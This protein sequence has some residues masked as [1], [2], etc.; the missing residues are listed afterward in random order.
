MAKRHL[1]SLI[2]GNGKITLDEVFH[3]IK[4]MCS[5]SRRRKL[6]SVA[7]I[8]ST[9]N[10]NINE[11]TSTSTT[12]T[13]FTTSTTTSSTTSTP[14][15]SPSSPKSFHHTSGEV[16]LSSEEVEKMFNLVDKDSNG[17]W[18]LDEFIEGVSA[19]PA[20]ARMLNTTPENDRQLQRRPAAVPRQQHCWNSTELNA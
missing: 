2:L 19:H 1:L 4:C 17:Y 13:T 14:P 16:S 10:N 3:V 12:S 7:N 9:D 18:S 8:H 20:F 15:S 5:A 11:A 6:Q